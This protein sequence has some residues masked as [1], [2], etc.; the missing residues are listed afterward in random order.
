MGNVLCQQRNIRCP[1]KANKPNAGDSDM[2]GRV[3]LCCYPGKT[4]GQR[5]EC[6][7]RLWTVVSVAEDTASS[8]QAKYT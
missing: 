7:D 6:T 8:S 3:H 1:K 2:P 4:A 5:Y